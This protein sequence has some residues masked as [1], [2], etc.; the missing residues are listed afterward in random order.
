MEEAFGSTHEPGRFAGDEYRLVIAAK[1]GDINAFNQLVLNYQDLVYLHVSSLLRDEHVAE[2]LSQI[3]FI[4]AYQGLSRY[5]NGSFR[6]WLLR[7]ATNACYDELR[8][9]KRQQTLPLIPLN[10]E[11]DENESPEWMLDKGLSVEQRVEQGELGEWF[12]KGLDQMPEE[13]R[14]VVI[15]VDV[16]GLEYGEVSQVLSIP[17]GTVKSRLARG[18]IRIQAHLKA[19]PEYAHYSGDFS[20]F[21]IP[22]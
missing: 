14:T 3:T 10:F 18:R 8:R 7:I 16:L 12:K 1:N 13:F 19:T 4:K 5:R 15:L 22:A 9:Q 6:A 20:A 11:E 21:G 2:D 17:I